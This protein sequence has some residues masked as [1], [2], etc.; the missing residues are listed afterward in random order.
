VTHPEQREPF[1]FHKT[2]VYFDK[3][4]LLPIRAEQF[5]FP[6]KSGAEPQ[7]VEEYTYTDVK[8]DATLSETDFDVN[9]AKYGFK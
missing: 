5:A 4:T 1:K 9:N 8:P 3:K 7:L 6:A 2:R